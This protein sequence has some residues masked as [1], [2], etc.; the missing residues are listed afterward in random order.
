[1]SFIGVI[2]D[3]KSFETIKSKLPDK[4]Q[5]NPITIIKINMQSIENIKNIYFET[6][7]I[8]SDLKKLESNKHILK[9]ILNQTKHIILNTDINTSYEDIIDKNEKLITYGLNQKAMITISSIKPTNI[10]IYLQKNIKN[11]NGKIL[12]IEEKLVKLQENEKIKIYE[13]LI[14]YAIGIIYDQKIIN[15]T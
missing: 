5:N 10:L 2:S 13:I 15:E 3:N 12:E 11:T 1:M 7:I 6:I 4:I 14:L 9:Q 8:N